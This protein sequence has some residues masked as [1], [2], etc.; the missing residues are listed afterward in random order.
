MKLRQ[1]EIEVTHIWT[2]WQRVWY[3][4]YLTP[5]LES[6]VGMELGVGAGGDLLL[7][8]FILWKD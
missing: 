4:T 7:S 6:T 3:Q 8:L 5:A 1:T 2:G